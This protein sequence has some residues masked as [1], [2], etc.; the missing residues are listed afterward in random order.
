MSRRILYLGKAE[1]GNF[2]HVIVYESTFHI[3]V[4]EYDKRTFRWVTRRV[5]LHE[6]PESVRRRIENEVIPNLKPS[7]KMKALEKIRDTLILIKKLL[8]DGKSRRGIYE[9]IN[10]VEELVDECLHTLREILP[11]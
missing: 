2:Y 9:V 4:R 7:K 1:D 5:S 6:V 3:Y 11:Y 8:E 10:D